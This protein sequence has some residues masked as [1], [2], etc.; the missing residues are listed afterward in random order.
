MVIIISIYVIEK[1][2]RNQ[3]T[4][5]ACTYNMLASELYIMKYLCYV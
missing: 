1:A 5:L 2:V 3:V 4:N